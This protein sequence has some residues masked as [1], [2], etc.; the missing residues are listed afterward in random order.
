MV[1][2]NLLRDIEIK[3]ILQE[4]FEILKYILR[5]KQLYLKSADIA[6]IISYIYNLIEYWILQIVFV[7]IEWKIDIVVLNSNIEIEN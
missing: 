1:L 5:I 4:N 6:E 2:A 3:L 7:D